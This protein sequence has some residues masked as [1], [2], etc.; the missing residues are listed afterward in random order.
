MS[1]NGSKKLIDTL[2]RMLTNFSSVTNPIL[3]T[4]KLWNTL[5]QRYVTNFDFSVR[6]FRSFPIGRTVST[7]G[8]AW[9]VFTVLV[10]AIL[11]NRLCPGICG[12]EGIPVSR[13]I[14]KELDKCRGV[15][16]DYGAPDQRTC[17]HANICFPGKQSKRARWPRSK[18]VAHIRW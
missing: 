9:I 11:S 2:Q 5:L 6:L 13:D 15:I 12:L 4:R 10:F 18:C 17:R 3:K 8:S 16:S 1:S 7:V 14:S